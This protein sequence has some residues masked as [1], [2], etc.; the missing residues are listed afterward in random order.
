MMSKRFNTLSDDNK[1][2]YLYKLNHR[3]DGSWGIRVGTPLKRWN[4]FL[5]EI[6]PANIDGK[7]RSLG[8]YF[9]RQFTPDTHQAHKI[10]EVSRLQLLQVWAANFYQELVFL[11]SDEVSSNV[12]SFS[13]AGLVSEQKWSLSCDI[14]CAAL[15][16]QHL[17]MDVQDRWRPPLHVHINALG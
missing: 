17:V 15:G 3:R 1:R 9:P 6:V 10:Q 16:V 2:P 5:I 11:P 12:A 8:P 13:L 14:T 4:G 7:Y